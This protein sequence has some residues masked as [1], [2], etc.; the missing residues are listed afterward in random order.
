M[1]S[2]RFDGTI[3]AGNVVTILT[4]VVTVTAAYVTLEE[5]Q[6]AQAMRIARLEAGATATDA[7]LRAAELTLAG[8]ASDLRSISATLL[9]IDSKIDRLSQRR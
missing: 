4:M 7:R 5:T 8:Q 6:E 9:K 3:S 2:F 1:P